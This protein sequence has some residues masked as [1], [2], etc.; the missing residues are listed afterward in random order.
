MFLTWGLAALAVSWTMRF[1]TSA[2]S[3]AKKGAE[4]TCPRV[5]YAQY[6]FAN[7]CVAAPG[8]LR[9]SGGGQEA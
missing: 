2:S 1:S 4:G 6:R 3:A 7:P 9:R 8:H 5:A